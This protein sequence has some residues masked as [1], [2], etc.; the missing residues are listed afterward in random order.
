VRQLAIAFVLIFPLCAPADAQTGNAGAA[1]FDQISREKCTKPDSELIKPGTTDQYNAQAK[2]FND[3]LRIYVETENNKITLI[4]ADAAGK[5]DSIKARALSQIHDIERAINTAILEVSIVNGGAQES[6]LPPPPTALAAFPDAACNRPDASLLAPAKGKR[7]AGLQALDRYELQ[8]SAFE[9]C[10]GKYIAQA[11]T[12]I[13]VVKADAEAACK[14]ITDD[15]NPRIIQINNDVTQALADAAQASG[16]RNAKVSAINVRIA[17]PVLPPPTINPGPASSQL[18]PPDAENV[19]VTG[20][21]FPRF[22]DMPTGAGDPDAISCRAPQPLTDSRLMGPEICKHN[23]DWAKLY[24][25]G[26]NLSPDGTRPVASEKWLS[27]HPQTC[28]SQNA[29]TGLPAVNTFCNQGDRY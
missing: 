26:F 19:T 4:R 28:I 13:Q 5:L 3:C 10:V 25:E 11:K 23:R 14:Q 7:A 29:V 12:E 9:S 17:P 6:E 15:A 20:D 21:R 18:P 2:G 27:L 22:A 1:V 16:E 24:K 8:H